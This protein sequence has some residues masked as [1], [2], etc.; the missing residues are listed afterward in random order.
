MLYFHNRH[1]N[2]H[3]PR[4]YGISMK[5]TLNQTFN[6]CTRLRRFHKKYLNFHNYIPECPWTYF[7]FHKCA[8]IG[9]IS[10]KHVDVPLNTGCNIINYLVLTSAQVPLQSPH[11]H[12]RWA[13]T[14]QVDGVVET[15]PGHQWQCTSMCISRRLRQK[16]PAGIITL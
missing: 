3:K 2:F 4:P 13:W 9:V 6:V 8:N 14:V 1:R 16:H 10:M 5:E 7:N 11:C 12:C 15:T